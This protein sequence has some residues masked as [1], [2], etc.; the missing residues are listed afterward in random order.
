MKIFSIA[1]AEDPI[2]GGAKG[3]KDSLGSL[4]K[5][6]YKHITSKVYPRMKHEVLNEVENAVVYRDVL[7]FLLE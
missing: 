6:G 1:G 4:R 3:L 7:E 5:V 2:T